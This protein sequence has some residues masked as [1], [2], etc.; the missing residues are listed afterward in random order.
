[1]RSSAEM[2]RLIINFWI[3]LVSYELTPS[4]SVDLSPSR[5]MGTNP[6]LESLIIA[7]LNA[8][9]RQRE[10][11]IQTNMSVKLPLAVSWERRSLF[12]LSTGISP[13]I[14]GNSLESG[15]AKI[16]L[17]SPLS[18]STMGKAASIVDQ[19]TEYV[20]TKRKSLVVRRISTIIDQTTHRLSQKTMDRTRHL[21]TSRSGIV[22]EKSSATETIKPMKQINRTLVEKDTPTKP[23]SSTLVSLITSRKTP[24]TNTPANRTQIALN[25]TNDQR[26]SKNF[27]QMAHTSEII[28]TSTL[29]LII[30]VLMFT[31]AYRIWVRRKINKGG[32]YFDLNTQM[33]PAS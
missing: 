12:P 2:W 27:H 18:V 1:M 19:S 16:R 23:S 31:K 26:R 32:L 22:T 21:E 17:K 24:D 3:L 5:N 7:S 30:L 6:T 10:Q 33:N 11:S 28:V 9:T 20:T 29:T 25:K 15:F 4:V 13:G 8:L 14:K